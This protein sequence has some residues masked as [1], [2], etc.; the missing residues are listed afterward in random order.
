[1]DYAELVARAL[2][3]CNS[4]LSLADLLWR[5]DEVRRE[6]PSL[7]ELNAALSSCTSDRIKFPVTP[8]IYAAAVLVN[9]QRVERLLLGQG[10]SWARIERSLARYASLLRA[11]GAEF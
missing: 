10:I 8:P 3:E 5:I 4:G 1:M 2:A 11:I 6:I 7:D 9:R